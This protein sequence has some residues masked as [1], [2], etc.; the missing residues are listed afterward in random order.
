MTAP[1]PISAGSAAHEVALDDLVYHELKRLAHSL[2]RRRAQQTLRTTELVHEAFL[3]LSNTTQWESRAHFFGS[4]ARAMR[5]VLIDQ[6]RRRR[7]LKRNAQ[8]GPIT[9]TTGSAAVT[10]DLDRL[11]VFDAAMTQLHQLN[12]R[13]HKVV[14]LRFYAG[15]S[16]EE[17][18]TCLQVTTRTVERDWTKAR[19]FLARELADLE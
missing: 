13:M 3:R 1:Q 16:V 19:L 2:L 10:V 5:L 18:A 14:E 6:A 4:A 11:L 9:L 15:L 17:V 12:P 7:A 8:R